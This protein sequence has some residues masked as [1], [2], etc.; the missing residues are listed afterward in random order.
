MGDYFLSAFHITNS[1]DFYDVRE[2][3]TVTFP[4]ETTFLFLVSIAAVLKLSKT[5]HPYITIGSRKVFRAL[6]LVWMVMHLIICE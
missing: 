6:L 2:V 5:S 1:F 4:S 3:R